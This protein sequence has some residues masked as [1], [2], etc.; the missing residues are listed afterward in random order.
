VLNNP[1]KV[2]GKC[3]KCGEPV[4]QRDDETAEAIAHRMDTYEEKTAPLI[5][6]YKNK[7]L[8][9]DINGNQSYEAVISEVTSKL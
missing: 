9:V 6:Y 2:E 1:P 8:V 5:G 7:D 3:D 4:M